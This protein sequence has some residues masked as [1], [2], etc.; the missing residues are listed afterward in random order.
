MQLQMDFEYGEEC[1]SSDDDILADEY[2]PAV[3]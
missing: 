2:P 3:D 1:K